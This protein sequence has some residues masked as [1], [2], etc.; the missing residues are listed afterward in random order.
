M[1]PKSFNILTIDDPAAPTPEITTLQSSGFLFTS[2]SEFIKAAIVTIAVPCWSS[3]KTGISN[4]SFNLVSISI[5]LGEEISSRFTPPKVGATCF[6]NLI[7]SS[8]SVVSIT[9]GTALS[10]PNFLNKQAFP[11][12]TGSAA[13]GPISPSPN[14]A[15]PS[16]ITAIVFAFPV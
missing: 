6:T 4:S 1:I 16:E 12:I 8:V 11:S 7:I 15:V 10:P 2:F 13:F 14:T 9:S 3:W 5:H